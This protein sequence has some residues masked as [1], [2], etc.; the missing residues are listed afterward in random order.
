MHILR[1]HALVIET[2]D[3]CNAKCAMCYQAAGPKGS[4]IRGDEH[5]PLAITKRVIEEAGDRVHI[6]GGE[7][8]IHFDEM[9]QIFQHA[10]LCEFRHIGSTTNGYWALSRDRAERYCERLA[11]AGV[12][13]LEVSMDY[14]HLPYVPIDRVRHLVWGAWRTGIRV[15][16]RTLSSRSHHMDE[17]LAEFS[18]EELLRVQIANST[19]A[20]VGRGE[21]EISPG[22]AYSSSDVSGCCES[23]LNLTIS[24]NGN[25]YPC[26]AGSDMTK[27][28]ACGNVYNDTLSS[29]VLSMRTDHMMREL[30]HRGSD[31]VRR[32][33]ETLGFGSRLL[34][35]Y[36]S[37]C[38]LCWHIFRDDEI[39]AALRVH[40]E[41]EHFTVLEKI[42][43]D[44]VNSNSAHS[45]SS[46]HS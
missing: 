32:I 7:G 45:I 41:R 17:L 44:L 14:W 24:P 2:T 11:E 16:L 1:F 9:L 34:P 25:V 20:P 23:L 39:A 10:K 3:R 18:D 28:L 43:G 42:L 8:F 22:E 5:L 40:Y 37:I 29:A 21:I 15:M 26:C 13:Y 38:H 6:S 36:S 33:V 19:M 4:D 27:S 35:E 46:G 31:S 12:S 30:I